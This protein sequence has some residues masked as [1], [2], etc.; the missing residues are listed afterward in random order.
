[1]ARFSVVYDACVLYPA[2]LRDFLLY[3]ALTD[4]FRPHWSEQIHAEWMRNLLAKR[5]D[6]AQTQLERTRYL[7][8]KAVPDCLV[9][10]FENLIDQLQLP[11]PD[12]RHVL[13]AAIHCQASAIITFNLHDF[14][15]TSLTPY[16]IEA[17]HPDDFVQR[18]AE[19]DTEAVF[20][21]ARQQRLALK[22]PAKTVREF[23][24]TL[25]AQGLKKTV[26]LL[27]T[28]LAEL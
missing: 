17:L 13:A 8:D 6:L 2:P 25:A 21:A 27:E 20:S 28:R 7:M 19:L 3:L 26:V 18:I 16:G 1:M 10:G 4:L 9:T 11:D 14:P 12:D 24:D 5:P 15:A 23:L 22:R